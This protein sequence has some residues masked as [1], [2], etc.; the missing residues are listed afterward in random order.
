MSYAGDSVIGARC[1]FGAGTITANWRFDTKNIKVK[2][3]DS[4]VDTGRDKL[5]A[6]IGDNCRTGIQVGIMPGVRIG[7]NSVIYPHAY[8]TND[9]AVDTIVRQ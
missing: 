1:S 4:M 9:V 3:G 6:F 7:N 5:G 8:L 2:I